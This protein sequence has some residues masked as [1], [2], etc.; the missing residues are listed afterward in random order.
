MMQQL[1]PELLAPEVLVPDDEEA[2]E[3]ESDVSERTKRM[4]R[5]FDQLDGWKRSREQASALAA[6]PTPRAARAL[7]RAESWAAGFAHFSSAAHC[8]TTTP[9]TEAVIERLSGCSI[10]GITAGSP[11]E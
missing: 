6:L 11:G 8:E 2:A 1:A 10:L 5:R 7:K 9:R 4:L 3:E